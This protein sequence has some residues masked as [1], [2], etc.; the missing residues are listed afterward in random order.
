MSDALISA[1][2]GVIVVAVFAFNLLSYVIDVFQDEQGL[3]IVLFKKFAV[4][5]IQYASIDYVL[6]WGFGLTVAFNIVNRFFGRKYLVVLKKGW[7]T[8]SILISP[9]NPQE[10]VDALKNA[11]VKYVEKS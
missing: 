8:K 11:N 6:D 4:H 7:F 5:R 3:K 9:A 10:F 2:I 1:I